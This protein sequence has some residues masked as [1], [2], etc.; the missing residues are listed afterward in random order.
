[1]KAYLVIAAAFLA[2]NLIA[3]PANADE[4]EFDNEAALAVSRAAIGLQ[5]A[6]YN[7]RDSEN[8]PVKLSDFKGKPVIINMIYTSCSHYCPVITRSLAD[9]VDVAIDALGDDSFTVLTIGFDVRNDKPSRMRAYGRA[10]GISFPN[11]HF[12]AADSET[13]LAL[14]AQTGFIFYPSSQGFDHLAQTTL[15]DKDNRIVRQIYGTDLTVPQVVEPLK[16]LRAG[17]AASLLTMDNIVERIRLFCTL[18]DPD[19]DAYRFDWSFFIGLGIGMLS[20]GLML[21][22]FINQLLE[23]LRAR[24]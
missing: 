19:R 4:A 23:H 10:Q 12:L 7:F 17:Q 15:L 2:L 20:I 1:M 8:K 21:T 16:R 14:S 18:Y 13:I 22:F 5:L 11:W 9:G 24:P 3:L 6:D